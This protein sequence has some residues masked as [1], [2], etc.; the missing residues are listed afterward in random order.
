MGA[1]SM[2]I[3]FASFFLI[4]VF[5]IW[6]RT[7]LIDQRK[8]VLFYLLLLIVI[9]MHKLKYYKISTFELLA[10]IIPYS[11]ILCILVQIALMN[12][13]EGKAYSNKR[14]VLSAKESRKKR[15]S[16]I[17]F[18]VFVSILLIIY[19]WYWISTA[20]IMLDFTKP[21]EFSGIIDKKAAYRNRYSL[22]SCYYHITYQENEENKMISL[23]ISYFQYN[24]YQEGDQITFVKKPGALNAQYYY[25]KHY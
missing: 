25:I 6:N 11:I 5:L 21:S 20:N 1:I 13:K 14:A 9:P 3:S 18:R 10:Y 17:F 12:R 16:N 15:I 8:Y 19:S 24:D 2:L 7:V 23:P 22:D 4:C